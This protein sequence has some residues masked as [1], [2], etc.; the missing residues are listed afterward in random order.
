MKKNPYINLALSAM[1]TVIF[2]A[3]SYGAAK[4]DPITAYDS[5]NDKFYEIII[6]YF[7]WTPIHCK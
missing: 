7:K 3:P 1:M 6:N 4:P 2:S 5:D